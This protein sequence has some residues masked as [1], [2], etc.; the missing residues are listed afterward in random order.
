[1]GENPLIPAVNGPFVAYSESIRDLIF[2]PSL[3]SRPLLCAGMVLQEQ[4]FLQV[5]A[6]L[7]AFIWAHELRPRYSQVQTHDAKEGHGHLPAPR[8]SFIKAPAAWLFASASPQ[9]RQISSP[10]F[11]PAEKKFKYGK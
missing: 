6:H 9:L 5:A 3:T 7:L 10:P 1:M 4:L 2:K 8:C 11:V